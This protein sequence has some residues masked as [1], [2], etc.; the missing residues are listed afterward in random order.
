M[1][2]TKQKQFPSAA[3]AKKLDAQME[4]MAD[5]PAVGVSPQ[6]KSAMATPGYYHTQ[7]RKGDSRMASRVAA[8]SKR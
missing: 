2:K 5:K 7:D 3:H 1:P 6:A 4:R 8:A